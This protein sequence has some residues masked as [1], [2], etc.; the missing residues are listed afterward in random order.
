[1]APGDADLSIRGVSKTF[2]G[3]GKVLDGVDLTVPAG[4]SLALLGPSGC[5]KTTLLRIIAGLLE[6]DSGSITL[7]DRVLTDGR[8]IV[9][10]EKRR[11]G[12]VFQNWALFTHLD[13]ARNVG[14]GLPRDQRRASDRIDEV[15]GLVAMT[16][17]ADRSTETLSGGQQQRVALARAL[18]PR[19][20]VLLL[21]EPFSNLDASM[22][23]SLRREVRSL[24]TELG[25]T[26]IFVTHDQEEAFILG[27]RLAVMDAGSV[28]Q[29][30][31]PV[32]IYERPATR[33]LASFVGEANFVRGT[34]TGTGSATTSLGEVGLSPSVGW[35]AGDRI[36]LLIRPERIVLTAV[37]VEDGSDGPASDGSMG[38]STSGVVGDANATVTSVEY[39]GNST[40]FGVQ[41]RGDDLVVREQGTPRFVT[42]DRVGVSLADGGFPSFAPG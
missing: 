4:T 14:F 17:F 26:S 6:P 25:V 29:T 39:L 8:T 23:T 38:A 10:A 31:T 13:V 37:G 2:P 36:D 11:V 3:S 7:G 5:G 33:W 35:A 28:V 24:L 18:A 41:L 21:D 42:G 40:R 9:P 32:E 30:G 20:E 15:L 22:R 19:P 27:D 1:M 12:M 34:A 16:E